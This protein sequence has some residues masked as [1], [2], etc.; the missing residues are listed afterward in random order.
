MTFNYTEKRIIEELSDG[1]PKR[2]QELYMRIEERRA[3]TIYK[4]LTELFIKG[5]L[6]KTANSQYYINR[7][8][9]QE[10]KEK[11]RFEV[12]V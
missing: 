8:R 12:K 9:E 4:F 6:K 11:L 10:I 5:Y 2:P 7:E 1:K 3:I